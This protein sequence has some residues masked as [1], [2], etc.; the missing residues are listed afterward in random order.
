MASARSEDDPAD[1]ELIQFLVAEH[2][3][4]QSTLQTSIIETGSRLTSFLAAVSGSV[5]ALAFVGQV[6]GFSEPFTAFALVLLPA[7]L[8]LG[9]VSF[10]RVL[11]LFLQETMCYRGMNRTR[12]FFTE[13]L[14]AAT[15]VITL[16]TFDDLTGVSRTGGSYRPEPGADPKQI[17]ISAPG[18]IAVL[19]G[20]LCGV[21]I[22]LIG[23]QLRLS[24]LP[25]TIIGWVA[26]LALVVLLLL[27]ELRAFG[28]MF[29]LD[30]V[31]FPAPDTGVAM[32]SWLRRLARIDLQGV[33]SPPGPGDVPE[34][35]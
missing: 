1:R 5:V 6:S 2:S 35:D 22:A 24:L 32:P 9:L 11:Q 12:R 31:R 16:S 18:T 17:L 33:A 26:G 10:E 23:A 4:M 14:P 20:I 3:L 34:R 19:D 15:S 8:F 29:R 25:A 13:R 7:L 30:P 28:S 27:H 21:I